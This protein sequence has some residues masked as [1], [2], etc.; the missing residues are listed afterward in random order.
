M[1]FNWDDPARLYIMQALWLLSTRDEEIYFEFSQLM[2]KNWR[3]IF[4]ITSR[5]AWVLPE[6]NCCKELL[7]WTRI[8]HS[9]WFESR[10]TIGSTLVQRGHL[11]AL[12]NSWNRRWSANSKTFET[13]VHIIIISRGVG[14]SRSTRLEIGMEVVIRIRGYEG[15]GSRERVVES[16]IYHILHMFG[17]NR[18]WLHLMVA[19]TKYIW[20][21]SP[22]S[23]YS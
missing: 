8:K 16:I 7:R 9:N 6:A 18:R 12:R 11:M 1:L 21:L 5:T 10:W 19:Y 15:Y 13:V 17:P 23:Y 22:S 2:Q 14:V 20:I 4:D 3:F